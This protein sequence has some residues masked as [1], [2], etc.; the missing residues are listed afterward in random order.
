MPSQPRSAAEGRDTPAS[1][2]VAELLAAATDAAIEDATVRDVRG[3]GLLHGIEFERPQS[4]IAFA[5]ALLDGGVVCSYSSATWKTVRLT[6][7]ALLDGEA[8][9]TLEHALAHAVRTA[10]A[11]AAARARRAAPGHL[12]RAS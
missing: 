10:R 1:A 8:V 6:P 9:A 11:D 12:A 5:N 7:P 4:A 3:V 2:I